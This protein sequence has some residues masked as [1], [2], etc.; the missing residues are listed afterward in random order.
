[1]SLLHL[2]LQLTGTDISL[3]QPASAQGRSTLLAATE[4]HFPR[5]LCSLSTNKLYFPPMRLS[6]SVAS[7][8]LAFGAKTWKGHLDPEVPHITEV[9]NLVL[10]GMDHLPLLASS[11]HDALLRSC[12]PPLRPLLFSTFIPTQLFSPTRVS[13]SWRHLP[14]PPLLLG[15]S[16]TDKPGSLP[17]PIGHLMPWTGVLGISL[18]SLGTWGMP[19]D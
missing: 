13:F 1:M 3:R 11:T 14:S 17:S 5:P 6:S 16:H 19:L 12:S 7:R 4:T 15:R 8:S 9:A 18:M 10:L 2:H